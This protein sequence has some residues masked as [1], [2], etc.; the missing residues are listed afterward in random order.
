MQTAVTAKKPGNTAFSGRFRAGHTYRGRIKD[1]HK[2]DPACGTGGFLI[3]AMNYALKELRKKESSLW[4]DSDAPTSYEVEELF[5]KR[6]E[7]LSTCVFG[8]DL[9]PSLV[10]AAKMNMVMNNDGSG[11]LFRE[12]SLANPHTWSAETNPADGRVEGRL[13][14]PVY[15]T[16]NREGWFASGHVGR[17]LA[18]KDVS[19][20]YIFLAL[21]HPVVQAQICALA[22]G[23]VVD[24][25]YPEDV[26]KV[27]IPPMIDY[28]YE[29]VVEAWDKF[30]IADQKKQQA[31]NQLTALLGS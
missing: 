21:S 10:R 14:S 5:R 24:A 20:G 25:V 23:S 28:P 6:T 2:I 13:G 27:I 12:N 19:P 1:D 17:V 16:N 22:C 31:C 9:N 3:T 11:G 30:D 26:E 8:I 15:I 18:K 7:Y 4:A 29:K